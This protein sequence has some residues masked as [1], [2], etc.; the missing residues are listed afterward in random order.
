M[1]ISEFIK[2]LEPFLEMDP[3]LEVRTYDGEYG[4]EPLVQ[5]RLITKSEKPEEW[6]PEWGKHNPGEVYLE[7]C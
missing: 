3:D 1:K 5:I 6:T 7:L 4:A 2:R